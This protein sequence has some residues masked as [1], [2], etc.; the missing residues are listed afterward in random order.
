MQWTQAEIF[1]DKITNILVFGTLEDDDVFNGHRHDVQPWSDLENGT[2][3]MFLQFIVG[4][5][6]ISHEIVDHT[7]NGHTIDRLDPIE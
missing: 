7:A 1:P 5:Q 6:E 4:A 2:G 3:T